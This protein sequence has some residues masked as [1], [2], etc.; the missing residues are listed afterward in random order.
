M[1][2]ENFYGNNIVASLHSGEGERALLE[3]WHKERMQTT[4]VN[5]RMRVER[6]I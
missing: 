3:A 2:E 5:H 6:D 1:Q 4:R